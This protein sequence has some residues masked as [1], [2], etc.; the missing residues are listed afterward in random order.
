MSH[1][2]NIQVEVT[3]REAL[4]AA[5]LKT[6]ATLLQETEVKL[7]DG[8]AYNGLAVALPGWTFPVVFQENGQ[9]AYDNYNG[10]WGKEAVLMELIANY[11]CEKAI[12]EARA[13]NIFNYSTEENNEFITL[14]LSL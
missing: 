6:G 12:I 3:D 1:T 10:Q 9:A 13:N 11:G 14:K 2:M 7:F 8:Q 5:C 4:A